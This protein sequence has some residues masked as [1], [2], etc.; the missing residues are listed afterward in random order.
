MT[1]HEYRLATDSCCDLTHAII[2][3]L[4]VDVLEFPFTLDGAEHF[5]D[6]GVTLSAAQFYDAM[7]AGSAP[8]T[9]Q[10]PMSSYLAAF[11]AAAEA[12]IPLIFLSFS[13]ALSGTHSAAVLARR[14]VVERFP[15]AQLLVIDSRSASIN[16]GLLVFDAARKR[17]DGLGYEA[18]AEWVEASIDRANGYFTIDTLEP[19]RRGGRVS[20]F[21]ALAGAMLDVKPVLRVDAQ[22]ELVVDKPVRGRKKSIRA[23]V[24]AYERRADDPTGGT[25]LIAHGDS[26]DDADLL[27]RL[28]RER[29]G[30]G[31]VV[32]LEVGPVIGSHTGP[33]MVALAFWGKGSARFHETS[34]HGNARGVGP[35]RG[36]VLRL[37]RMEGRRPRRRPDAP[38]VCGARMDSGAP[39]GAGEAARHLRRRGRSCCGRVGRD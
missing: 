30:L 26:S 17:R 34:D 3:E 2:E 4:D 10:V 6:L 37:P 35:H 38:R 27:E 11:S 39:L 19:L 12:G 13:S 20:D 21:A 24:D 14:E 32:R 16:Q 15:D 31:E 29:T 1:S 36:G 25:V 8:T 18:L 33:G 5:D 9:A 7:R 22:G 28:L 23:L